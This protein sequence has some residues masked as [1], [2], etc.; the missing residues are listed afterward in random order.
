[1]RISI[2]SWGSPV[3]NQ[4]GL[5]V[6]SAAYYSKYTINFINSNLVNAP[7]LNAM[8]AGTAVGT[9]GFLFRRWTFLP[10]TRVGTGPGQVSADQF[11]TIFGQNFRDLESFQRVI[12]GKVVGFPFSIWGGKVGFSFGGEFR[13]EGFKV[14]GLS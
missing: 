1:M 8:I 10:G 4:S 13:V 6:E 14:N 7:Q 9:D 12:D 2:E 3:A 11:A 5:V